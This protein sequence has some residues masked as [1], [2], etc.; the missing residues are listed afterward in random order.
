MKTNPI[1]KDSQYLK[2]RF[3]FMKKLTKGRSRSVLSPLNG[4]NR[5]QRSRITSGMKACA[6]SKF[7]RLPSPSF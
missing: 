3:D 6:A 1:Y 2:A 5:A 7:I 4:K